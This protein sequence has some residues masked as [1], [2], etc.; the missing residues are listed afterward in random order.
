M[1]VA[2]PEKKIKEVIEGSPKRNFVESVDVAIN[3]KNLDMKNPNNRIKEEIILPE[4]LGVDREVAVFAKGDLAD[5]AKNAGADVFSDEDIEEISKNKRDAKKM[6]SKYDFFLADPRFMAT[7]GKRLGPVLGPRGKM[8]IPIV[9]D[10]AVEDMIARY[11]KSIRINT[12]D[13]LTFHATLGKTTLGPEK[14]SKNL[15]TVLDRV[16]TRLKDESNLKS[17]YIKTTMGISKKIK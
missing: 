2:D 13:N 16:N 4:G 11:K 3:L 7:I 9:D 10:S 5:K 12:K 8:P 6:A 15:M 1:N 14:L 17:V